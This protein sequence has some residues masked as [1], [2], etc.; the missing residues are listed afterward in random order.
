[1][2]VFSDKPYP[3]AKVVKENKEYANLLSHVYSG[4]ESELTEILLYVYQSMVLENTN[5]EI[6]KILLE[7]S[8]VEMHHLYLLGSTIKNL[9][10]NPI[11]A[12][13][14]FNL[15]TYWNSNDVYYDTDLNTMLE[16][17]IESERRAIHDYQML[18]TVINDDYIKEL[19]ERII[20]D[21]QI[22]LQIFLE[23]AKMI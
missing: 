4:S 11:Y 15:K 7:I 22:H 3:Q 20:L 12:D 6:A 1:M 9:G 13:C 17:D 16:I 10:S 14:N 23:L 21:E 5:Q 18:L 19:I 8:K 2:K